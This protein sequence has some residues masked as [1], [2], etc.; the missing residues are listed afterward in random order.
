M[1]KVELEMAINEKR[2]EMIKIGMSKGLSCEETVLC[3]QELDELLN[4]YRRLTSNQGT[5]Q[6]PLL[7]EGFVA[8]IQHLIKWTALPY[9]FLQP[10]KGNK[11]F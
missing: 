5:S 6:P 4:D 3:S 7:L 2:N 8:Y 10:Y 9:K 1:N 11:F